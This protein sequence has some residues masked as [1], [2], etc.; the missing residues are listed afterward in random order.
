[1]LVPEIPPQHR[2][3]DGN[4]F[5]EHRPYITFFPSAADFLSTSFFFRILS[6]RIYVIR[7]VMYILIEEILMR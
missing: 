3:H 7:C 1:M 6:A 2:Q 5:L 4:A